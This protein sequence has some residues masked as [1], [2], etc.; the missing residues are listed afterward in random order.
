MWFVNQ[1]LLH[2]LAHLIFYDFTK[3]VLFVFEF[4]VGNIDNIFWVTFKSTILM[5]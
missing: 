2:I 1:V 5:L 4:N 3:Q